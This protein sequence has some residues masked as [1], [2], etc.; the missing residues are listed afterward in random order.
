MSVAR[1]TVNLSPRAVD[2]RDRITARTGENTTDIICRSV[3]LV[4][5]LA[6]FAPDGKLRVVAPDGQ[7]VLVVLP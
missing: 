3:V 6:E 1:V 5:V 7:Q 2:A 4:D